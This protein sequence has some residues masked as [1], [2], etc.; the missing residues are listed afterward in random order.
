MK[1]RGDRFYCELVRMD[2]C[3]VHD[4]I[5]FA[6]NDRLPEEIEVDAQQRALRI[7]DNGIPVTY[8]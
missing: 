1:W 2:I 3:F 5:L 6:R 7:R 8:P 4:H